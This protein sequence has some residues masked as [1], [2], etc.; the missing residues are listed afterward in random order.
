MN[1]TQPVNTKSQIAT[2]TEDDGK[3]LFH[4]F[5]AFY[6]LPIQAGGKLKLVTQVYRLFDEVNGTDLVFP[7]VVILVILVINRRRPEQ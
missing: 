6:Y 1:P 3:A 2:N 4:K 5:M 7:A